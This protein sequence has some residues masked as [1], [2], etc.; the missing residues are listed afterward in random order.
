MKSFF[1][2]LLLVA[3]SAML[4]G[5]VLK[6]IPTVNFYR[7]MPSRTIEKP[8]VALKISSN[9]KPLGDLKISPKRKNQTLQE[10]LEKSSTEAFLV[11]KKD[12]LIYEWYAHDSLKTTPL[13]SFSI[14]KSMLAALVG[15]AIDEGKII[16]EEER[17]IDYVKNLDTNALRHLKISHLLQMT[18]G[19]RYSEMD[20]FNTKDAPAF[21][22]GKGLRYEPGEKHEYWSAVYQLLGM[23][24]QEAI[25]P[26]TISSYLSEKIW[27]P[28]GAEASATWSVDNEQGIEKSFCCVQAYAA[29]YARFGLLFLHNG[30]LNNQQIV[31]AS[32]VQKTF[33]INEEEGSIKKYNYGWWLP[34]ENTNEML[35]KGFRGQR[36]FINRTNETVIVRLGKNRS[37]LFGFGWSEFFRELNKEL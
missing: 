7:D 31:P 28:M 35:A 13:T 25:A 16:S 21:F 29:D 26:Q 10:F 8:P 36:V 32:W 15:I 37:G 6:K 11:I 17:V 23:V 24:L 5:C 19:T 30:Q 3:L 12:E 2:F 34:F 18:S 22:E 14:A 1:N 27:Q 9:S 20:V 4:Y 33:S